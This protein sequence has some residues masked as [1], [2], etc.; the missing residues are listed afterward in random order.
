[1]TRRWR[2]TLIAAVIAV[3][4]TAPIISATTAS[5]MPLSSKVAAVVPAAPGTGLA[6]SWSP[7]GKTARVFYVGTDGQ[8]YNWYGNGTT[9]T[10]AVLGSGQQAGTGTGLAAFWNPSGTQANVFYVGANGQIF[11]WS[12]NGKKW[13]N[14]ALGSG[15]AAALGTG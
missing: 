9:W 11:T 6:A 8:I 4:S 15:E 1:M 5:A 3:L 2:F 10:S 12:W 13:T 14:A 7:D